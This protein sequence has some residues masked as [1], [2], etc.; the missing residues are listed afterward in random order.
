[1]AGIV[2]ISGLARGIDTSAHEGALA[3]GTIAVMAGGVDVVYPD[4]RSIFSYAFSMYWA[5][6][7]SGSNG[8]GN[9]KP[10]AESP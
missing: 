8:A 2:V 9:K 10:P 5:L 1:V 7:I 4:G 6:V 3:T